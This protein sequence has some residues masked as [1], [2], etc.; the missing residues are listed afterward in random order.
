MIFDTHSHYTSH[1]FK[2]HVHEVLGGLTGQNVVNVVDCAVC[3]DNALE[4][5]ELANKY[6]FMRVAVG[7]HPESLIEKY[8][9]TTY[10]YKGDWRSEL[11][12]IEKL[13]NNPKVVAVGE[14]GLDYHW[15]VPKKEQEEMFVAHL[16]LAKK[17]NKPVLMHD[18]EAH[19]KMYEILKEYKPFG[20]LH[21]YSGSE[22]DAQWIVKQGIYIGVG[23]VV[24]FNNAKKLQECVAALP[25]ESMVIETDCPYL[26]PAPFRGKECNSAMLI[27]VAQ[28]IADIK[29]ISTEKVLEVTNQTAKKIFSM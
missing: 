6:D 9:S 1:K 13:L 18:R 11:A 25:L 29:S 3:Y 16:E 4:C 2:G 8:A 17:H 21:C 24:T 27:H 5:I 15:P 28:K 12:D 14:C 22:Q 26:A 23:G 20:I 7:I 19:A 10:K